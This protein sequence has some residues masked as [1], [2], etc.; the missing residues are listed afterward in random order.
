MAQP[1]GIF[2]S[3]WAQL[4]PEKPAP[5]PGTPTSYRFNESNGFQDIIAKL[6]IY[7]SLH[8]EETA[9]QSYN[10]ADEESGRS[11]E[12]IWLKICQYFGIETA[13]PAED[14]TITGEAWVLSQRDRW[15][16]QTRDRQPNRVEF[17]DDRFVRTIRFL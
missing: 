13:G 3:L 2:L 8:P 5:F 9:G 14:D 1:I 7:V 6:H 10:I 4:N 16:A 17:Y 15:S 12:S 11:W